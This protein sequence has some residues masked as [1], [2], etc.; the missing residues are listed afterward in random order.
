MLNATIA[1]RTNW[2]KWMYTKCF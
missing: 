1:Q 2:K